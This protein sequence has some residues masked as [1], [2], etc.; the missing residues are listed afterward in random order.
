LG[1]ES[2]EVPDTFRDWWVTEDSWTIAE[3]LIPAKSGWRPGFPVLVSRRPVSFGFWAP[4][5][6]SSGDLACAGPPAQLERPTAGVTLKCPFHEKSAWGEIIT[7]LIYLP[8][9]KIS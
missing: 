4:D 6:L 1:I 9:I 2:E 8:V 3:T 5:G 7:D